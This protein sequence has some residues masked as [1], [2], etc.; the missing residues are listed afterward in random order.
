MAPWWPVTAGSRNA[1]VVA[2]S[3]IPCSL[4]STSTD[5]P[6]TPAQKAEFLRQPMDALV[7]NAAFV[8]IAL[9]G[10]R[11]LVRKDYYAAGL[12][13]DARLARR[14]LAGDAFTFAG[15]YANLVE[16]TL[17]PGTQVD[18]PPPEQVA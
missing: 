15:Q 18:D 8:W 14:A 16:P 13:Q 10:R 3:G 12:E 9:S 2:A 6:V 11:D 1:N 7:V 5:I 4:A 17:A